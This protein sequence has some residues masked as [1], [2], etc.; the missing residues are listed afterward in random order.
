MIPWLRAPPC[1]QQWRQPGVT[2]QRGRNHSSSMAQ[3]GSAAQCFSAQHSTTQRVMLLLTGCL[4]AGRAGLP[5]ALQPQG[6]PALG[7]TFAL[8]LLARWVPQLPRP[9]LP[10]ATAGGCAQWGHQEARHN[11]RSRP[12][13]GKVNSKT[14]PVA[15]L[16]AASCASPAQAA[17]QPRQQ[18]VASPLLGV[19]YTP[20][21]HG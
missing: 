11:P 15:R 8:K 20:C 9:G 1:R 7:G 12:V 3:W 17:C 10:R 14:R 16:C 5:G 18:A 2:E 21:I 13:P 4:Q 19:M 6:S